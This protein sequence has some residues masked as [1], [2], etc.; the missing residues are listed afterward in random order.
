MQGV[1]ENQPGDTESQDPLTPRPRRQPAISRGAGQRHAPAD[2]GKVTAHRVPPLAH[3]AESIA[4]LDRREMVLDKIGAETEEIAGLREIVPREGR[5]A[6][7]LAA[8]RPQPVKAEEIIGEMVGRAEGAHEAGRQ[9]CQGALQRRRQQ[10]EAV[11]PFLLLQGGESAGQEGQ[12]LLPANFFVFPRTA[13]AAPLERLRDPVGMVKLL[14][15]CLAPGAESAPVDRVQGIP[16]DLL[17]PPF[18]EANEDAAAGRTEAAGA[19]IVIGAA[20][21]HPLVRGDQERNQF[22]VP[23]LASCKQRGRC[24]H[25]TELQKRSP[26]HPGSLRYDR[27][28]NR[29]WLDSGDDNPGTTPS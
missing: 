29:Y 28:S 3:L 14:H 27:S 2:V 6:E 5:R 4:V 9:R 24:R 15:N 25:A 16:F 13:R 8:G 19:G 12:R 1:S 20:G 26:L 18:G 17:G 22:F 10:R 23:R 21:S 7:G 11:A